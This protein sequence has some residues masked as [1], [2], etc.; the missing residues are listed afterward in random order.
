MWLKL[1]KKALE[2]YNKRYEH[3][4][5]LFTKGVVNPNLHKPVVFYE[6]IPLSPYFRY[7]CLSVRKFYKEI[8]DAYFEV[9]NV[10]N[11][12]VKFV[13]KRLLYYYV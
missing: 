9:K 12:Y 8:R 10:H 2:L 6:E 13:W 11:E 4:K 3:E 5:E 1:K 7:G